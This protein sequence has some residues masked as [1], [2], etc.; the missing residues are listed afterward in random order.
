MHRFFCSLTDCIVSA[1]TEK[2]EYQKSCES[3]LKL[4]SSSSYHSCSWTNDD[5]ILSVTY[6]FPARLQLFYTRDVLKHCGAP[7]SFLLAPA[8]AKVSI[9]IKVYQTTQQLSIKNQANKIYLELWKPGYS[10]HFVIF[11]NFPCLIAWHMFTV[12]LAYVVFFLL[13]LWLGICVEVDVHKITILHFIPMFYFN[14]VW[15]KMYVDCNHL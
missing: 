11:L 7:N 15:L 9:P 10:K 13:V 1:P 6:L 14:T 3:Q 8:D 12:L 4:E 2:A 5:D